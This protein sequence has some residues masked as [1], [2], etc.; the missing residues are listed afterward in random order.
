MYRNFKDSKFKHYTIYNYL[1][2][3]YF[4]RETLG[5]MKNSYNS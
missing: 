3:L 5:G 1:Y 4:F 2:W